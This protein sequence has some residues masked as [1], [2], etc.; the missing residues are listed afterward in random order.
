MIC[1]AILYIVIS[2]GVTS[3]AGI[4]IGLIARKGSNW[5]DKREF[6]RE[7]KP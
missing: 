7:R 3:V 6:G 5:L 2:V 4:T 1:E